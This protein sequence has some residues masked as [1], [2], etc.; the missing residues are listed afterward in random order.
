[1]GKRQ[2]FISV[3]ATPFGFVSSPDAY[4]VETSPTST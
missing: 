1:V 2:M 3:R 4:K